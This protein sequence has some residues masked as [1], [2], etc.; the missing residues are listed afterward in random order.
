M[1]HVDAVWERLH[2]RTPWSKA[3][4]HARVR[5]ALTRFLEWHYGDKRELVGTEMRFSTVVELADGEQ[6]S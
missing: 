3:R 4:E 6:V 5:R 1:E 2:F